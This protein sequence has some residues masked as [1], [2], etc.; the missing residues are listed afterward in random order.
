[1]ET[2]DGVVKLTIPEGTQSAT[3]FRLKER[4]VPR[5]HNRG[6]GDHF[7]EVTVKIPKGKKALKNLSL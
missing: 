2:V 1:V 6:R 3:V 4:G 5:L 7:L